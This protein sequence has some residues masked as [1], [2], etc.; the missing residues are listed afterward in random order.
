MYDMAFITFRLGKSQAIAVI[1]FIVGMSAMLLIRRL[2][3][4][5][6]Y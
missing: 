4:R 5:Q 1:L 3:R 6:E 2:T